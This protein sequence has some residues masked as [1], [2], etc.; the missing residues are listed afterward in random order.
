MSE[1]I[2]DIMMDSESEHEKESV[3]TNLTLNQNHV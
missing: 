1:S 3:D 2:G